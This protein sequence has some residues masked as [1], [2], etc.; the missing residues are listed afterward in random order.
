LCEA[1]EGRGQLPGYP[2]DS[3]IATNRCVAIN[4]SQR[5][6]LFDHVVGS[7]LQGEWNGEADRMRRPAL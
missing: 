3:P 7:R 4:A 5:A 1:C 6:S 2:L